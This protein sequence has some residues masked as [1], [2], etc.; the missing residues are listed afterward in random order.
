MVFALVLAGKDATG[1]RIIDDDIDAV[2]ATA[3]NQFCIYRPRNSVV[4]CLVDRRSHPAIRLGNL[5]DLG[6]FPC[7]VIA[8]T[9]VDKLP[10]LV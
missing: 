2:L 1:Q 8:Q 6:H 4:H 7:C 3:G 9:E 5:H 10:F